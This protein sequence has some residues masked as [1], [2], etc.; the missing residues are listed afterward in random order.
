MIKCSETKKDQTCRNTDLEQ[1]SEMA[2]IKHDFDVAEKLWP[3]MAETIVKL[4]GSTVAK[5]L[6]SDG[7][8]K[9]K[10]WQVCKA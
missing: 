8:F 2:E 6:M 5:G 9:G 7:R 10:N 3:E 4:V 1:P